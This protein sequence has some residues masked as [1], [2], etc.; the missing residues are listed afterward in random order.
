MDT[1]YKSNTLETMCKKIKEKK[2]K[3]MRSKVSLA[4]SC[5]NIYLHFNTTDQWKQLK[6]W[7]G[8][9]LALDPNCLLSPFLAILHGAIDKNTK[10]RKALPTLTWPLTC[11]SISEIQVF[12]SWIRPNHLSLVIGFLYHCRCIIQI[13]CGNMKTVSLVFLHYCFQ[14]YFGKWKMSMIFWAF[15][16]SWWNNFCTGSQLPK[17]KKKN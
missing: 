15:A 2:E 12:I 13:L 17:I 11:Y 14:D 8:H 10:H 1:T 3:A 16:K 6:K 5:C 7:A 9:S 4:S